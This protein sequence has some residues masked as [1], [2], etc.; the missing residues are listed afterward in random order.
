MVKKLVRGILYKTRNS[1]WKQQCAEIEALTAKEEII[2]FPEKY[3]EKLLLQAYHDVPYHSS[4]FLGYR[5][6][7]KKDKVDL[8]RFN[9]IPILTSCSPFERHIVT[10]RKFIIAL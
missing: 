4:I 1:G 7:S 2:G 5:D 9:E 3:L 8:S 6:S 10:R